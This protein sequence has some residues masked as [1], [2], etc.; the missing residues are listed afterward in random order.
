M[1]V[2]ELERQVEYKFAPEPLLAVQAL[3]NTAPGEADE[4]L[5]PDPKSAR[6]WLLDS[7]LIT[8]DAA[9]GEADLAALVEFRTLVRS[10]LETNLTG[11]QDRKGNERLGRLAIDHPVPMKVSAD[12]KFSLDVEPAG[13]VDDLIAQMV[14]IVFQAQVDST[15]PRLKVC[16]AHDCRWAFYDSSRNRGGTWCQMEVCGNRV[17]NRTYR[18]RQSTATK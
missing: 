7:D 17:K 11:D 8:E 14:G 9:V 4:E 16:A 6:K 18:S 3:A 5:L 15:W 10:L 13:S 2:K 1:D 12:G